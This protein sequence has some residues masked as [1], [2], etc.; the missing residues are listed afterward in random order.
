[1]ILHLTTTFSLRAI[2]TEG[3]SA[4]CFYAEVNYFDCTYSS[5]VIKIKKRLFPFIPPEG[6]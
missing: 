3:C 6:E 4:K 2:N 1:M 5:L